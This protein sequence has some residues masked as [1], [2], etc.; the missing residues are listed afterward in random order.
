MRSATSFDERLRRIDGRHNSQV[1][2]L[3]R[4]FREAAPNQRG[5]VAIEG[6]HLVEEVIRSGLRLSTVFL[7]ESARERAHKLLPQLSSHTEA[8]LLPDDVFASAVP[9][10]TP[11]GVAALVRVKPFS[12][13][14]LLQNRQALLLLTAGLQDPGNLGTIARSGDAFGATGLVLGEGTVSPWNWKATRASAGALFRVPT[15]KSSLRDALPQI[16]SRGVRL[17]ATSSHKGAPVWDADLRSPVAILIGGEG[18]GVPKELLAQADD[19]VSIPQSHTLESLNAGIAASVVLYEA[20]RQR[21][22]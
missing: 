20:A 4:L 9:S 2:E 3:R 7:S 5:D 11:Q 1:K 13:D 18:A 12:L 22:H 15:C 16:K 21:Q 10:E 17:L 14:A 19:L 6:M 8:L